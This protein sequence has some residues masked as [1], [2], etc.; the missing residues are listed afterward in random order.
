MAEYISKQAIFDAIKV[1]GK[2][3]QVSLHGA[4]A[5]FI[6]QVAAIPAENVAPVVHC[7]DCKY[8]WEDIG[9]LTCSHGLCVD[10]IVPEDFFCADG[11]KREVDNG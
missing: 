5:D 9:G 1:P 7:K 4:V 3:R 11:A 8:S 10:C 6:V 2:D